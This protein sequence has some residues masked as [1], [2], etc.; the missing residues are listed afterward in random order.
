M[1]AARIA[2][3]LDRLDL[4]ERI[5]HGVVHPLRRR[6][7]PRSHII[8][9]RSRADDTAVNARV[10]A[11]P[12]LGHAKLVVVMSVVGVIGEAVL[13]LFRIMQ[14]QPSFIR[15]PASPEGKAWN[16]EIVDKPPFRPFAATST[17]RLAAS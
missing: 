15:S 7:I 12:Q 6:G 3:I 5:V 4:R 17:T 2:H 13:L 8:A 14:D 16:G 10:A 1:P 11:P 9:H